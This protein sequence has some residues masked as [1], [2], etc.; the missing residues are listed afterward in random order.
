MAGT[1]SDGTMVTDPNFDA[2]CNPTLA[3]PRPTPPPMPHPQRFVYGL[4]YSYHMS[5][6]N[7]EKFL[8]GTL[9]RVRERALG[10]LGSRSPRSLVHHA[11]AWS[12]HADLPPSS[13]PV[14][15]TAGP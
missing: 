7:L 10:V 2:V 4:S 15:N 3:H 12:H 1:A 5:G 11:L 6:E 13:L 8:L 14:G 9:D